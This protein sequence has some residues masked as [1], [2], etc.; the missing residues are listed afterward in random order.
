MKYRQLGN[1]GA[2][3]SELALGTGTFGAAMEQSEAA[4][5]VRAAL[6]HGVNFFD[7]A[8]AYMAGQ[9]ETMLGQAIRNLGLSRSDLFVSSKV[10]NPMGPGPNDRG[11][12]RLHIMDGV[13]KSLE[14]L[15]PG[16]GC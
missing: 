2:F 7:T 1:T 13:K 10:N 9:S 5:M 16:S 15:G 8:D 4:A 3:V 11:S 6:D 14:R 12:S